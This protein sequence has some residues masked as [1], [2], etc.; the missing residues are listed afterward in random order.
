MSPGCRCVSFV[1]PFHLLNGQVVGQLA[2]ADDFNPI[3]E[4]VAL[5]GISNE[6]VPVDERVR[7]Q[8]GEDDF[9][10]LQHARAVEVHPALNFVE[11]PDN[12]TFSLGKRLGQGPSRR[13]SNWRSRSISSSSS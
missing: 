10:Y 13:F 3:V 8:L 12:E 6:V 2:G 7:Q 4:D 5:S 1:S 9:G 11:C